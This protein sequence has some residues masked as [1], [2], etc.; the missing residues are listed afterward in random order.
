M[1]R[2]VSLLAVMAIMAAMVV[3]SAMPAFA[4]QGATVAKGEKGPPTYISTPAEG[5]VLFTPGAQTTCVEISGGSDQGQSGPPATS[6][7][8]YCPPF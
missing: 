7:P 6:G 8:G 4:A 2:V 5:A 1:K 3:A